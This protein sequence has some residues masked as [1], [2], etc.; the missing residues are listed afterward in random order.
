MNRNIAFHIINFVLF[1][2]V[3]VLLLRNLSL[4]HFGFFYAYLG[5]LLAMPYDQNKIVGL[6]IGF[7]S[8]ALMDVFY[9]TGGVHA[10]ACTLMMFTRPYLLNI[11]SPRGGFELGMK[12]TVG[13]LGLP[14][15]LMYSGILVFVHHLLLF[16]L[17]VFDFA[18]LSQVMLYTLLS[19][20]MSVIS[21]TIVHRFVFNRSSR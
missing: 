7:A 10:A 4:F 16:T 21:I 14:W 20:V 19:T 17:D 3:Q 9:Q 1:F 8:G 6:L 15:Y 2:G 12:M 18:Y 13:E 5:F 11:I